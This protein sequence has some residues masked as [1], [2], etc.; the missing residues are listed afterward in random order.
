M[1]LLNDEA[2]STSL[3]VQLSGYILDGF[4]FVFVESTEIHE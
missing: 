1:D 4:F 2:H 3:T